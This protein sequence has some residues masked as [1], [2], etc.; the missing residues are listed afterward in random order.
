MQTKSVG[1]K[2]N[3]GTSKIELGPEVSNL[4]HTSESKHSVAQKV[5]KTKIVKNPKTPSSH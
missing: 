3:L 2:H 4:S 5:D 1:I